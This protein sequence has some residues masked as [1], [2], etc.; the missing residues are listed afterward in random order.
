MLPAIR[1]GDTR[2]PMQRHGIIF[3]VLYGTLFVLFG[4]LFIWFVGIEAD[5]PA[6]EVLK[7]AMVVV[8]I[9][10]LGVISVVTYVSALFVSDFLFF[11]RRRG[12]S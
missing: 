6:R 12:G 4:R 3:C 5:V 1:K 7:G 2:T 8:F 10:G 11:L 9:A